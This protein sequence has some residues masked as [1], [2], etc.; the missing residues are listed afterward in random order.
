MNAE[1]AFFNELLEAIE[2][3]QLILPTQP[4][5]A[6]KIRET[7]EDPNVT[8]ETLSS[9]I[10]EDPAM[11]A[12]LIRVANS[13]L[14]RGRVG[15][16]SLQS[17]INRLGL[18]F[19]CNLATGLAMEQ[20]F[21]ATNDTVEKWM[22]Q[23]WQHSAEVAAIST[24][25]AKRYTTL[26]PDLATLAGL[27]HE[28]GILPILA[29]CEESPELLKDEEALER[30]IFKVH[31]RLGEAILQSWDFPRE[32]SNIPN[33]YLQTDLDENEASLTDVVLVANLQLI[34]DPSH[35]LAQANWESI[36]AFERLG[37]E[38]TPL[39]EIEDIYDEIQETKQLLM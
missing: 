26:S 5:V 16:E 27:V 4:E 2:N 17:A 3:N 13:P 24:V 37:I 39:E 7:A 35:P 14:M 34:K 28:I 21:Q 20:I 30:I 38:P 32:I 6:L 23:V 33:H 8:S 11:A 15:I 29:K 1:E 9:V 18:N 22:R 31:P 12:R 36:K 19:V 10:G 25:I